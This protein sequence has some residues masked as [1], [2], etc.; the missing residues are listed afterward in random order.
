MTFSAGVYVCGTSTLAYLWHLSNDA[1]FSGDA[2][3]RGHVRVL[4]E[5]G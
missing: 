2:E 3:E 4:G 5:R 1:F